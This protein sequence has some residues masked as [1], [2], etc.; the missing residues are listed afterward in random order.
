MNISQCIDDY[1]SRLDL[2]ILTLEARRILRGK[3]GF[4]GLLIAS[5]ALSILVVF[6]W[7]SYDTV[8]AH[9][10]D[11]R[12]C[13]SF[14]TFVCILVILVIKWV[15]LYLIIPVQAS[16]SVVSERESG[17]LQM[18]AATPLST[19]SIILQKIGVGVAQAGLI[20]VLTLPAVLAAYAMHA[21][22]PLMMA[23]YAPY[24][25]GVNYLEILNA[26]MLPV[27]ALFFASVGVVC[28]CNASS[29]AAATVMTYV[30][31]LFVMPIVIAIARLIVYALDLKWA[32]MTLCAL[33][34]QMIFIGASLDLSIAWMDSLRR[35]E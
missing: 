8:F 27:S 14:I 29:P 15:L 11:V 20:M 34:I 6:M 31:T 9:D 28:S 21:D 35:G 4:K 25:S 33:L 5:A 30:I 22:F 10:V 3:C 7:F 23:A 16:R 17:T 13:L 12:N 18:L 26:L 2:P 1:V 32:V 24:S 19:W